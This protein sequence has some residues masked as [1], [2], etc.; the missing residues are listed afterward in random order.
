MMIKCNLLGEFPEC[1]DQS[2][3]SI[4]LGGLQEHDVIPPF[5]ASFG[6]FQDY[7][8]NYKGGYWCSK[9]ELQV[10]GYLIL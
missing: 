3:Y 6:H 9:K 1:D 4:V 8:Y 2:W 7:P 10:F 5:P